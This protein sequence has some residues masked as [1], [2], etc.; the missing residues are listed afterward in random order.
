MK[1]TI[2]FFSVITGIYRSI[3]TILFLF[4]IVFT[5]LVDIDLL[6]AFLDLLG[7][8]DISIALVKPLIMIAFAIL[9][10]VNVIITK[11]IFNPGEY[12]QY[13]LSNFVFGLIFLVINA[14]FYAGFRNLTT[15]VIYALFILNG[16]L[17]INSL[18]GL[19]AKSRGLY[20]SRARS[21]RNQEDKAK[22]YIEFEQ[23]PNEVNEETKEE[24]I[25]VNK[26][27]DQEKEDKKSPKETNIP[28]DK[29]MV[30]ESEDINKEESNDK[31]VI[32]K[33]ENPTANVDDENID[34][35]EEEK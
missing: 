20:S 7:F 14:F 4:G 11:H 16:I 28:K 18:L 17:I 31:E 6:M 25:V 34:F 3:M 33:K 30:F 23:I 1:S 8:T 21:K 22:E 13:H 9:F 26:V 19:I 12:G 2:K 5:A 15:D 32:E 35:V 10:I 27:I 29:K 24:N